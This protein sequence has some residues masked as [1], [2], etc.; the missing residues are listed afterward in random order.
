MVAALI[1]MLADLKAIFHEAKLEGTDT[2]LN[3]DDIVR[4]IV[5]GKI[6]FASEEFYR[7]ESK[8]RKKTP[9]FALS[10]DDI[11]SN[12]RERAE[13]FKAQGRNS[14]LSTEDQAARV[15]AIQS[16]GEKILTSKIV[17]H[18][19]TKIQP[20]LPPKRSA[21]HMTE[22]CGRLINATL[23][24]VQSV[25]MNKAS[26]FTGAVLCAESI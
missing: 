14:K 17:E 18:S 11:V 8:K 1:D 25:R 19:P 16:W 26:K 9:G 6:P 5:M 7:K 20:I 22:K 3:R 13:I 21:D 12:I 24:I 10:F 4:Q 15:L 23:E 2:H